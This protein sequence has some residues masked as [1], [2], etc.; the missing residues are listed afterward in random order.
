MKLIFIPGAG[1]TSFVWQYQTAHFPDSEAI[2]FPGHPEGTPCASIEEYAAWLHRHLA[3]K[4]YVK[5]VLVGHSMGAAIAL[6]YA[7][8]YP[9]EISGLVLIGAGARLRVSPLILDATKTG[10]GSPGVWLKEFVEPLY[11][12]VD[13]EVS[14]KMVKRIAEVGARVQLNDF[15]CCDKFD[16]M[17]RVDQIKVPTL[18]ISGTDDITTPPKYA[19]FLVNKIAGARMVMVEGATHQVIL[20]KPGEVNLA[21]EQFLKTG[22]LS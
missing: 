1:N 20:E 14:K 21:I 11:G 18:V 8:N 19:Q 22:V 7:L 5:P 9:G 16:I 12:R 4:R 3:G 6:M 17:D 13:P 15:E 2:T 10:I